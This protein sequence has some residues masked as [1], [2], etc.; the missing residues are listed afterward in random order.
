MLLIISIFTA[1]SIFI[2]YDKN[3]IDTYTFLSMGDGLSLGLNPNGIKSYNYN[4]Y[5]KEYLKAKDQDI[6]YFNYSEK[7]LSIAELTNDIIYLN[8]N[9]LK[10][11]LHQS[12]MIIL[13]IGE[14]EINDDKSL[15]SIKEDLSNLLTEIKKYNNNI[16]LLS[17][18]Y[19]DIESTEKIKEIN[20][21]YKSLAKEYN[22]TYINIGDISYY[23]TNKSN[24][25][26][27]SRGYEEISKLLIKAINLKDK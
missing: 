25:Y 1:I 24:H 11:Y 8:N 19:I 17:K 6:N 14:K 4:D 27:T 7:N 20:S 2:I 5:L 18:Y 12:N 21:M 3:N 13:S 9:T 15:I 16:C 10:E 23:L 26:P 22:I